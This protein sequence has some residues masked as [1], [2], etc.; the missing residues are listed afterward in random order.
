MRSLSPLLLVL[1]IS[2]CF[3]QTPT[4]SETVKLDGLD[5]YYEV[6]G[7]GEPLFLL[8]GWGGSTK[9]WNEYISAFSDHFKVYLVDLL[10]HG[11][12]SPLQGTFQ[13]QSA[14]SNLL[15][16]L[17]YLQLKEIKAVG[18]S[19]GGDLLLQFCS[20][21]PHRIKSIVVIGASYNFPKQDW[22]GGKYEDLTPDQIEELRLMHIHGKSQIIALFEQ[23]LNYEIILSTEDLEKISTNTLVIVGERD[24][25]VD[26][27]TAVNLHKYLPNSH[28][29]IVPNTGHEAHTNKNKREF[30]RIT[31]EFLGDEW[32]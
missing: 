15:T 8:H 11:K 13:L 25:F 20:A 4:K 24:H 21:Y 16:L 14:A 23:T 30:I 5:T 29:W 7:E 12:S 3:S 17:D 28:L 9:W 22:G 31:N 19:Y 6:Y 26:L 18:L 10:G 1:L 27:D 32:R 2:P